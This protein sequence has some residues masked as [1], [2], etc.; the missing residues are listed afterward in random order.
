MASLIVMG[1]LAL[2]YPLFPWR[3]AAA[4]VRRLADWWRARRDQR[5]PVR[6]LEEIAEDARRLAVAF[7]THPRGT[8]FVKYEAHRRAYD[9]VLTEACRAL[10]LVHLLGVLPPGPE[11]DRERERVEWALECAG[12]ELGLLR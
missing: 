4:A 1:V 11:L 9:D 5:L 2:G 7:R 8:S 6:P 10:G 3:R 12:L